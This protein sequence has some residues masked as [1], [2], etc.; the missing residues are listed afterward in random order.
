VVKPFVDKMT[1]SELMAI[2]TGGMATV[3]GGVMAAYVGLLRPYFPNIA[4]HLM[5]ASIMSAPAA[6]VMAK[7]MIPET[8]KSATSGEIKLESEKVDANVID[9]AARGAGEGLSLALN[10]G[11]MLLA[12]IALIYMINSLMIFSGDLL[13]NRLVLSKNPYVPVFE[14]MQAFKGIKV[15]SGDK[16][17]VPV[18]AQRKDFDNPIEDKV[19]SASTTFKAEF[20]ETV[21][22]LTEGLT[23]RVYDSAGRQ[24][25][26]GSSYDI[27]SQ[28]SIAFTVP[29]FSA[30]EPKMD[31]LVFKFLVSDNPYLEKN[32]VNKA[33]PADQDTANAGK[34]A[35]IVLAAGQVEIS[36]AL[37]TEKGLLKPAIYTPQIKDLEFTVTD[38]KGLA[39]TA[40]NKLTIQGGVKLN[41]EVI[42]GLLF[43]PFAFIMGVPL[44]DCTI[45]GTLLGEKIVLNEFYAYVHLGNLL[46]SKTCQLSP[47]SVVIASYALCGFANFQSIAIQIGGIGGIAPNRRHEL[48]KLGVKS[49]IAG[50]LA[51]FMTATI[52]GVFI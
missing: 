26:S 23:F 12:F 1:L 20:N 11:G 4:G 49:M 45:I 2:M 47:R 44:K 40:G 21:P 6:L 8:E 32:P 48:A 33:A 25:G 50:S 18:Q 13:V 41:M 51:A 37:A 46:A 14:S 5:A 3:A 39:K 38:S 24:L 17:H 30:F 42:L 19:E 16:I 43:A 7:I 29:F 31:S 15:V 36:S 35:D 10:V 9:A 28:S 27:L 34:A 52:A 22:I